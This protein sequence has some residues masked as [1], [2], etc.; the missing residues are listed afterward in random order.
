MRMSQK[1]LSEAG[2]EAY[3]VVTRFPHEQVAK[4]IEQANAAGLTRSE[5]IRRAVA[6]AIAEAELDAAGQQCA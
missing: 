5:F 3:S 1:P 4:I 2:G 6:D